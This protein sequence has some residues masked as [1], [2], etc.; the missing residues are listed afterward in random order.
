MFVRMPAT[1]G[2]RAV[3]ASRG[4]FPSSFDDAVRQKARWLGGI[5]LSRLGP[6]RLARRHRRALDADAR[7]PRAARRAAAA[8]AAI[9]PPCCGPAVA[10]RS[11]RRAGP[12]AASTR[13]SRPCCGSTPG[14]CCGGSRCAGC[15]PPR[16]TAGRQGC[17]RCRGW[18]S[19]TSI[20]ILAALRALSL[21]LGGS[22]P[23]W[24]KTR[25]I[26]PAELRAMSAPLRFLAVAVVGWA[27]LPRGH[28]GRAVRASPSAQP[29]DAATPPPIVADRIVRRSQPAR[30]ACRATSGRRMPG[31]AAVADAPHAAIR[32]IQPD[33]PSAA[34]LL[35]AA[36]LRTAGAAACRR[37]HRAAAGVV[38]A[39]TA[40]RRLAAVRSIGRGAGGKAPVPPP[41]PRRRCRKLDRWQL[42]SWALLRGAPSRGTLATGGTLGGSQAGRARHLR[43]STAR[44]P[45]RCAPPARSAARAAAEIAAGVRWAPLRSLPGRVH[46]RAAAVDRPLGGGR[47]AFALFA[48]GGLYRRPLPWRFELDAYAQAGRG[49][50]AAA[51]TCSPTAPSPSPAR[52]R[53]LLRRLRRV[54]RPSRACIG[55][56]P[57]RGCR[58][59]CATTSA[60]TSTIASGSPAMP[61]PARAPR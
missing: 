50:P 11:A 52:L 41:A 36:P 2:S 18:W 15:S 59:G 39:D 49:R 43:C 10:R 56:T 60:R 25:H 42:S 28:A 38:G 16:P 4:H 8:I 58:S 45:R 57:G 33:P 46:R 6:A 61:R 7:P 26:F 29:G 24:D 9:S 35:R 53:P 5:A 23:A 20:A 27:G 44:W 40:A 31:P 14:C 47:S 32:T 1:P 54:G 12:G 22:T 51:A 30:A 55:S 19:A 34:A 3:V 17:C 48:E 13:C 21:Y 37:G